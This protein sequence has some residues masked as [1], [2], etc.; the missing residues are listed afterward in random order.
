MVKLL[1]FPFT[2]NFSKAF[3]NDLSSL[4]INI[5]LKIVS[6]TTDLILKII[7]I[8]HNIFNTIL[9]YLHSTYIYM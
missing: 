6:I 8:I 3:E 2:V 5:L 7:D 1:N 9:I 4:N